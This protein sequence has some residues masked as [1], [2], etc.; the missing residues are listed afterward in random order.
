MELNS[1]QLTH[2]NNHSHFTSTNA[3][4]Y[5]IAYLLISSGPIENNLVN[6]T[7][8]MNE[9]PHKIFSFTIRKLHAMQKIQKSYSNFSLFVDSLVHITY[10][11]DIWHFLLL[12]WLFFSVWG[13]EREMNCQRIETV[14]FSRYSALCASVAWYAECNMYKIK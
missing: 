5:C 14:N 2:T 7:N 8:E 9:I 10:F 11:D 13:R 4:V 6:T 1:W 3:R 12:F